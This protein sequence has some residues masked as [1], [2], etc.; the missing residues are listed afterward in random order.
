MRG[1]QSGHDPGGGEHHR[2]HRE[3]GEPRQQWAVAHD[4][5][6]ELGHE[7]EHGEHA[8]DHQHAGDVGTCPLAVGEEVERCDRLL[9]PQ[10]GGHEGGEQCRAGHERGDGD[11]I[12]PS[13]GGR[14]HEPVDQGGHPEGRG[15]RPG[16]IEPTGSTF[17][18]GQVARGQTDQDDAD[19]HVDEQSPPPRD[20]GGQHAAQHQADAASAAGH[21]AVGTDGPGPIRSLAEADLE[22]GEGGRRGDGRADPLYGPGGQQPG[23][24]LGQAS[25]QRGEG[26]QGD[27]GH[28]DLAPAED[29]AGPGAEQEQSAEG[30]GVGV[31][32]P[33]EAGGGEVQRPVDVGQGGDDDGG[34]EDDHQVGGQ[35]D[36]ED[37]RRIAGRAGLGGRRRGA[38]GQGGGHQ[39]E[40]PFGEVELVIKWRR[41][42]QVSGG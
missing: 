17:G 9:G 26:E 5:L 4:P 11:R 30:Q 12:A 13:G 2:G 7:E 38:L 29:V 19:G 37:H 16:E 36:A 3:E 32:Y 18:L 28:E 27:A 40:L 8:A 14:P 1:H 41:P 10:F 24:G 33:G 15:D 20:P 42:P 23:G 25:H 31:L 35:D 6:E 22:E 39:L 21:R 34:V